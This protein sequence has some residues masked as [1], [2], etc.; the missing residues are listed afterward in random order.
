MAT[1]S[2]TEQAY[3]A[4]VTLNGFL[5]I[6]RLGSNYIAVESAILV[7]RLLD[8]TG[9]L[10]IRGTS[11]AARARFTTGGNIKLAGTAA[12]A[13][14]EGV[15]AIDI[16]DGTAPVGTLANGVSIYSVAGKLWAKDAAG[17]ATQLTP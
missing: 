9:V 10:E 17:A 3:G 13:T 12:R 4:G 5:P 15:G 8:T 11:G 6:V 14:T 1:Q 7:V 16:F 2:S